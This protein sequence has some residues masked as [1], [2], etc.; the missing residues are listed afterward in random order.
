MSELARPSWTAR[1][2]GWFTVHHFAQL[3][4]LVQ[5]LIVARTAGEYVRQQAAGSVDPAL[6]EPLF[7]ALTAVG[8]ITIA[9]LLLYFARREKA[10]LALTLVGIAAL[11]VYK[12]LAMPGLG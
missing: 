7:I 3:A 2:R 4:L 1:L 11:I 10:V 6:V 9:T 5:P 12:L 8:L